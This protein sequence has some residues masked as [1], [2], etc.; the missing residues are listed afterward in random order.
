MEHNQLDIVSSQMDTSGLYIDKCPNGSLV[1][2]E[3]SDYE[4]EMISLI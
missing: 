4:I 1:Q 3:Y 2:A